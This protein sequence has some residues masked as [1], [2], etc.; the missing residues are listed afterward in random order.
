[1]PAADAKLK[2]ARSRYARLYVINTTGMM[3][4]QRFTAFVEL[5]I[6]LPLW[7]RESPPLSVGYRVA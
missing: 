6:G 1:M 4:H 5:F 3:Y 7:L 2:F